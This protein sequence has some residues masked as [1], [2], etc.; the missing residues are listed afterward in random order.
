MLK[1][2]INS[3]LTWAARQLNFLHYHYV[4]SLV[5]KDKVNCGPKYAH[6]HVFQCIIH[7]QPPCEVEGKANILM[8]VDY[9]QNDDKN[10]EIICA[11]SPHKMKTSSQIKTAWA[12][13]ASN[14]HW[15]QPLHDGTGTY[16]IPET[17]CYWGNHPPWLLGN[18]LVSNMNMNLG[19][20]CCLINDAF[21]DGS[22]SAKN[23]ENPSHCIHTHAELYPDSCI[24]N[25]NWL[26]MWFKRY[27]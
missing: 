13:K 27:S 15:F 8:I 17:L 4:F 26:K 24:W 11:K 2:V 21:L 23:L 22:D 9:L 12:K 7:T 5:S 10:G 16:L 6:Q 25:P 20:F 1:E 18:E 19:I 14:I 3:W